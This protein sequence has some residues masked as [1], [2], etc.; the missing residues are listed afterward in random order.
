MTQGA[1]QTHAPS[2][3]SHTVDKAS[4]IWGNR[5]WPL[6][7]FFKHVLRSYIWYWTPT[8]FQLTIVRENITI[9]E[10]VFHKD[11]LRDTPV[12]LCTK[13]QNTWHALGGDTNSWGCR[14]LQGSLSAA[15][16]RSWI[17]KDEVK[18]FTLKKADRWSAS[19]NSIHEAMINCES[20]VVQQGWR[21]QDVRG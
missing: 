12:I 14:W 10:V 20:L 16:G 19:E 9:L 3:S 11:N 1:S 7:S 5:E 2:E 13:R 18:L 17:S 15:V 4:G 21:I 8:L 6:N